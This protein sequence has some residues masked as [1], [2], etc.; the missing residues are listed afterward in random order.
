[1]ALEQP[2]CLQQ[3]SN[4]LATISAQVLPTLVQVRA[5]ARGIGAGT[6][7]R[8]TGLI[9]TN[10]HVI[11]GLGEEWGR[12]QTTGRKST[13][14]VRLADGREAVAQV[15]AVQVENDLAA[16]QIDLPD[17]VAIPFAEKR[18]LLPGTVVLALGFPWGVT[19]GVTSGIVIDMGVGEPALA[20]AG[21][22][23]L[24]ASLH[25]RPGHSGG[26][27]VDAL[28]RLVGINTLM[29]GPDVGVAVPVHLVAAFL[30]TIDET[31]VAAPIVML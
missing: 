17:L 24:A 1:M 7:V 16:L 18:Q 9:V 8:S 23:W 3:L 11:A 20:A 25:L 4:G 22:D 14:A 27:M 19:G 29:T 5:G 21:H 10:A 6:I 13:V 12:H 28:G 31:Q 26:P 2:S 15:V 30:Q